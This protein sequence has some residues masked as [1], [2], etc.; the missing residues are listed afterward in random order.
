M[1]H[2]E[3]RTSASGTAWALGSRARSLAL[4]SEGSAAEALYREAIERLSGTRIAVHLARAHLVYG[5]WLRRENRRADARQQLGLAHRMFTDIGL[6]GFAERAR[7]ELAAAGGTSRAGRDES[8]SL[9]TSQESQIAR[10]A[11]EGLSN[12]EI[13]AELFLSRHTV[14]WHLRK[15]FAKLDI[16]SRRQLDRVPL[17][18]LDPS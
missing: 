6:E 18:R 7:R 15:V 1:R 13:G 10:L 17:S 8:R 14:E 16:S 12:P 9:L 11:R 2:I 3:E 5:E 4:L